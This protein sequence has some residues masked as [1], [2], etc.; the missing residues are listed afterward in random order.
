MPRLERWTPQRF[1]AISVAVM[2]AALP[3]L[4]QNAQPPAPSPAALATAAPVTPPDPAPPAATVPAQPLTPASLPPPPPGYRYVQVGPA[5]PALPP[6]PPGYRYV[7]LSPPVITVPPGYQ[8]PPELPYRR[9]APIPTGYRIVE[10]PRYGWVT[11]GWAI[12]AVGY[13]LSAMVTLAANHQNATGYLPIPLVGPWLTFGLRHY[14]DCP[15]AT[16][17]EDNTRCEVDV[18]VATGIGMLGLMQAGGAAMLIIGYSTKR[19][20]VVRHDVAWSV[21]PRPMGSGYGLAAFGVF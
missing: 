14:G 17:E 16:P 7:R 11:A 3:A 19:T 5:T 15:R 2:S 8:M 13:G 6:P 1:V 12:T 18:L 20:K 21:A 10:E 4:A 9:G